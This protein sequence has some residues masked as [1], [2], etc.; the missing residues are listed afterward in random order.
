[1]Y[2]LLAMIRPTT[3]GHKYVR[4]FSYIRN[5]NVCYNN[6]NSK[7]QVFIQSIVYRDRFKIT[8]NLIGY[9][10][11]RIRMYRHIIYRQSSYV[12][13]YSCLLL[14]SSF[15][16]EKWLMVKQHVKQS[17]LTR[18]QVIQN[19]VKGT[20]SLEVARSREEQVGQGLKLFS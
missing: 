14:C 11:F 15:Y 10:V 12:P 9:L 20:I 6:F 18:K 16:R 7:F 3:T 5:I 19:Q 17:P 1:M 8:R 4:I 13:P 2:G